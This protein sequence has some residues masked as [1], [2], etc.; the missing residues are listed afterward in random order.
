MSALAKALPS[1]GLFVAIV[2]PSGAG[3]DALIRG[4]ADRLGEND[5]VCKFPKGKKAT[6]SKIFVVN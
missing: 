6:R 2:G 3:K 5:G 1:A 4:L